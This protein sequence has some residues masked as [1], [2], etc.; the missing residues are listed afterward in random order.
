MAGAYPAE[1]AVKKNKFIEEWN[2]QREITNLTFEM[3]VGDVGTLLTYV[4]LV[5][6]GIYVWSRSELQNRGDR[7]YK[8]VF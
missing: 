5:P 8:E 3:S 6:L 7:R 1:M 4:V 2:G